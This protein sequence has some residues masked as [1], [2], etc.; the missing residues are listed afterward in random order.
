MV[1]DMADQNEYGTN[2]GQELF[3]VDLGQLNSSVCI[4]DYEQKRVLQVLSLQVREGRKLLLRHHF[5]ELLFDYSAIVKHQVVQNR[6]LFL[7]ISSKC[8]QESL[9]L[10]QLGHCKGL[11]AV[12]ISLVF[13]NLL[14]ERVTNA[15]V[16]VENLKFTTLELQ[17]HFGLVHLPMHHLEDLLK[18]E[19][20]KNILGL[21]AQLRAGQN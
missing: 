2:D 3:L 12:R 18:L 19:L 5:D 11:A 6:S 21:D 17:G 10:K 16:E 1:S 8:F 4:V 20:F 9:A 15:L 14:A 13:E 7:L